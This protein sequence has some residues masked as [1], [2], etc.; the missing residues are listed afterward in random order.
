M[1]PFYFYFMKI[2]VFFVNDICYYYGGELFVTIRDYGLQDT[3]N[4]AREGV[5]DE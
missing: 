5:D 2:C 4:H 3:A 1:A